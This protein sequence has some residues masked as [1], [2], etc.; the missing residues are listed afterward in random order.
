MW[1][2]LKAHLRSSEARTEADLIGAIGAA[3]KTITRQD[4]TNWFAHG[5][6]SFI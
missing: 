2:K 6:Y 4:A 3:L 1:S 5:G